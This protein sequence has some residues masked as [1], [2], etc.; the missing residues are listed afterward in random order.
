MEND[1]RLNCEFILSHKPY[2]ESELM[3]KD[4]LTFFR[5]IKEAEK[6]EKEQID[7]MN[8]TE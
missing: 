6:S 7:R 8:K 3:R 2:S 4:V 1:F 5:L